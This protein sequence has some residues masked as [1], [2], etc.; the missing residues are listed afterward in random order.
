MT[1]QTLKLDDCPS[2]DS[3]MIKGWEHENS[4]MIWGVWVRLSVAPV[5]R[6]APRSYFDCP[7]C[8]R[9]CCK[10]FLVRGEVCHVVDTSVATKRNIETTTSVESAQAV[11]AGA[12]EV[13]E[14]ASC[15]GVGIDAGRDQ[16]IE[17]IAVAVVRGLRIRH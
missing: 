3:R 17:A 11:V 7:A 13:V 9:R 6:D 15:F 1:T 8:E 4:I 5:I 2:E 10:L 14:K 16:F 12:I